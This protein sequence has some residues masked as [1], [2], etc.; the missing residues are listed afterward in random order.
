MDDGGSS[1]TNWDQGLPDGGDSQNCMEMYIDGIW[2][3]FPCDSDGLAVVGLAVCSKR[4]TNA[5]AA[6][7]NA[8][9]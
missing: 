4:I 3:D 7:K 2:N 8:R 6:T 1:F 9:A 5:T